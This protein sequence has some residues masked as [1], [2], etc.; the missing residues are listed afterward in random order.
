VVEGRRGTEA[1]R[2]EAGLG[3]APSLVHAG[4]GGGGYVAGAL[5]PRDGI[6]AL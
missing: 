3:W 6:G 2:G 5:D 1:R 4:A